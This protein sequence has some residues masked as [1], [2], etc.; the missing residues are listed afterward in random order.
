MEST[1]KGTFYSWGV[2][3]E[4]TSGS[5]IEITELPLRKWT[6]DYK[7][8]LHTMLPGSETKTPINLQDIREYHT[9]NTVHFELKMN[10]EELASAKEKG[11]DHVFKMWGSVNE[12][13]M[14]LFDSEGRIKK[15]KNVLEILEEFA[16]VRLKYY[17]I[18]KKY[19][20]N[21][22]TL[23]RDLLSN[24]ARFIAMI[25]AKKLHINNR[26]K[27]DI[28][29]DLTRLKF[30]KF[31]DTK[32]PRTGFEY[33]LIMQIASLTKER[34]EE[35]ERMAKE[36]A[37]E[38][39]RLK[40]TSIQQMWTGDLDNLEKAIN[41][42][43]SRTQDDA[44]VGGKGRKRKAPASGRSRGGRS[45]KRGGNGGKDEEDEEEESDEEGGVVDPLDNPFDDISRWTSG[46]LKSFETGSQPKKRRRT[47]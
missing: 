14:V 13:N 21:K 8:F 31:G 29:K 15:Y 30:Q 27:A 34:K 6:Q 46:A 24:R 3:K 9:E 22:L 25:V 44:P 39:E 38:L 17:D 47:G 42:L 18:R 19:L 16:S 1:G 20:V 26:K 35:L 28:V 23:E 36:K 5:G 12:T 33:L 41:E 11:V 2:W 4:K 40:K 37:A 45:G 7:E 32:E 10:A 43:Y